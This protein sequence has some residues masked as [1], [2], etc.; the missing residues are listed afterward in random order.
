MVFQTAFCGDMYDTVTFNIQNYDSLM[1]VAYGDTTLCNNQTPISVIANGGVLPYQYLW[2]NG[3][4][5]TANLIPTFT[6]DTIFKITVKDACLKNATDSVK[7]VL[8]CDFARAGPDVK[9]CIGGSTT[10]HASID[11]NNHHIVGTP[12]YS[13]SNG[14]NT[15]TITVSPTTTTTYIVTITDVFSDKDSVTVV[16]NPLP[17]VTATSDLSTICSNGSTTLHASGAQNYLW[18]ANITDLSLNGQYTLENPNVSPK[19]STIYTLKGTD[20]DSCSNTTNVAVN[21]SPQPNI[22]IL[23]SPNPVSVFEP[24]VH[25]YDASG[26]NYSYLWF[27]G[28]G[29]TSTLSNFYHTYSDKDTGRY[30]INVIATNAFGCFDSAN[31]VVIVRPD[32]TFYVPNTFTPNNDGLNDIFKVYGM[33]VVTFEMYIYDRWGKTVYKSKDMNEGWDGRIDN[34]AAPD[35]VYAYTILYKDIIG[36]KHSKSGAITIIR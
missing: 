24:I 19:S 10:L 21:V 11:T 32:E 4:G 36:I 3:A 27:L 2:S 26:G 5:T 18:S 9:I 16:V 29:S 34:V 22:Q 30:L 31:L 23:A 7:I 1:A 28:D 8:D 33:G 13:W 20:V 35:G 6:S 17:I 15:P 14:D 25:I 12:I